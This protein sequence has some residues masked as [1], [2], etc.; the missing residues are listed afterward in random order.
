MPT[1]DVTLVRSFRVLLEAENEED[2]KRLAEFQI[3]YTDA[4]SEADRQTYHFRIHEIEMT[5]NEAITVSLSENIA[6]KQNHKGINRLFFQ[7]H[8][9]W[10]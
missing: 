7:Q 6:M 1:Y 8:I 4:S 5:D 10:L 9:W 2:A 3:G